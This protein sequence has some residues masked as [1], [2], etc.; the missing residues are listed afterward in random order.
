[1][2]IA[3]LVCMLALVAFVVIRRGKEKNHPPGPGGLPF[4]GQVFSI[5]WKH[6][7]FAFMKWYKQYGPIYKVRAGPETIVVLSDPELIREAFNKPATQ[8]RQSN[9][10]FTL[11]YADKGIIFT[12]GELWHQTRRFTLFHLRNFGMGKSRLEAV[13]HEQIDGF[14]NVVLAPSEGRALS[15]NRALD[16]SVANIIWGIV[17]GESLGIEDERILEV[18]DNVRKLNEVGF[19]ILLLGTIPALLNLPDRLTGLNEVLKCFHYPINNLLQPAINLHK[20]SVDLGG[21][22]RDYIDCFLQEQS[23]HPTLYTE[24][25]LLRS[26]I[27]LFFAG[28]DTTSTTLR[29]AFCFL[30]AR[31][32]VQERLAA[33]LHQVVGRERAPTLAD[34]PHLPFTEA[35][36]METQRLA[37]IAP[38]GVPH[39]ST[40][41]FQLGGYTVPRGAQ[42]ISLLTAVH[43]NEAYFPEPA[44]FLPERFLDAEGKVKPNKALMPFSVG[45]R[46]CMGEAMARAELFL[47]VTTVVQKFRLRFP[48]GF[49][50]DFSINEE[51]AFVNEP[52]PYSLIPERR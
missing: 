22:P 28:F 12:S 30:C 15:L 27:D 21:E 11:L 49:T 51:R 39:V 23:K 14:M 32:D 35:V 10:A 6:Q 48:D 25:H 31:P 2:L 17:A 46:S 29:W 13:I 19:R 9:A 50:H 26:L 36:L 42:V 1:M 3:L 24:R 16:I 5:N 40:A 7:D 52:L 38:I 18:M 45:K 47:F 44:R 33:E 37:N 20:K 41:E 8:G 34:R 4:I 43:H